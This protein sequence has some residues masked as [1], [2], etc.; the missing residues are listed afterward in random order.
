MLI[1]KLKSA[2]NALAVAK[3]PPTQILLKRATSRCRRTASRNATNK[4]T[5]RDDA[6]PADANPERSDARSCQ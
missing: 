5:W 4:K 1:G 2:E 6:S 3:P